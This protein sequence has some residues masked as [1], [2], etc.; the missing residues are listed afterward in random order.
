MRNNLQSGWRV[1]LALHTFHWEFLV[2]IY[3]AIQKSV[4]PQ[5]SWT[6]CCC[7]YH[8]LSQ[9]HQQTKR[10]YLIFLELIEIN[11]LFFWFYSFSILLNLMAFFEFYILCL[12]FSNYFIY[13][14]LLHRLTKTR[15][16]CETTE[17]TWIRFSCPY[18]SKSLR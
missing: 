17:W 1:V 7:K 2:F 15:L 4:S 3:Q 12:D 8:H 18:L 14:P 6:W 16:I 11:L 9:K 13:T 10:F 5:R